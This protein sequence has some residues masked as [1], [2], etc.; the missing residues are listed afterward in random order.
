MSDKDTRELKDLVEIRVSPVLETI[1]NEQ[2]K[3]RC[4]DEEPRRNQE[5]LGVLGFIACC[6]N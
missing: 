3:G 2:L 5:N 6:G 4:N 1:I